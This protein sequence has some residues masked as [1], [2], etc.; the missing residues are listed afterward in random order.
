MGFD[1]S[2]GGGSVKVTRHAKRRW[3]ERVRDPPP[4]ALELSADMWHSAQNVV[5]PEAD[6][7]E[8]RI[9]PIPGKSDM[10]LCGKHDASGV[11]IATVLYADYSRIRDAEQ[12]DF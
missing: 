7:D 3:R 9:Y 6:C 5:A 12:G 1:F 11:S 2:M 4:Q 8:S 10:L